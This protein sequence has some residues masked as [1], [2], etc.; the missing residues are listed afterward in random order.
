MVVDEDPRK[1]QRLCALLTSHGLAAHPVCASDLAMQVQGWPGVI[2]VGSSTNGRVS[3]SELVERI[4][5]F[6]AD[7]PVILLGPLLTTDPSAPPPAIQACLPADPPEEALL[8]EVVRW[9]KRASSPRPP[10]ES[11]GTVLVV[12]D[13]AK[14]RGILTN[15]LE[16]RGFLVES[17]ASGEEGLARLQRAPA[18]A[19][20]LDLKMPGMDGLLTLRHL[21]MTH[22]N[23]P[24]VI[25]TNLDDEAAIEEAG[26]LGA[27]D[28][29]VKPFNLEH[30]QT[31]LLTKIFV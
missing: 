17:A 7:A 8:A 28:Y 29:L 5:T 26:A 31:V 18:G 19:V 4:R 30:L 23:L 12:D 16:L 27:N 24:V 2:L 10:A 25:I 1:R 22:P 14:I 21:R 11:I 20:L 13:D 15:F 9:L 6:D 3:S